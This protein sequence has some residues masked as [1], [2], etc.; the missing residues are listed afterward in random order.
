VKLGASSQANSN[1]FHKTL[2][3]EDCCMFEE[4]DHCVGKGWDITEVDSL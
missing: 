3:Y 4:R 2:Q 1:F